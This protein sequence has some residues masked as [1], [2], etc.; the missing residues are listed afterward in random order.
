MHATSYKLAVCLT[1]SLVLQPTAADINS[2]RGDSLRFELH[3]AA[4]AP[5]PFR[6]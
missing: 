5:H 1:P 4:D 2:F 3:S 6:D